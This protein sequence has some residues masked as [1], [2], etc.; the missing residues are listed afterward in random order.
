MF[1]SSPIPQPVGIYL[2]S[3]S[4]HISYNA[5][6]VVLLDRAQGLGCSPVTRRQ[7]QSPLPVLPLAASLRPCIS[8]HSVCEA[9]AKP[10]LWTR[11]T[12]NLKVFRARSPLQTFI[13]VPATASRQLE[14]HAA[15]PRFPVTRLAHTQELLPALFLDGKRPRVRASGKRHNATALSKRLRKS[16][17]R[18][19]HV[20]MER[21]RPGAARR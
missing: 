12:G 19:S 10:S 14:A 20:H 18:F 3:P 16:V 4:V 5:D 6:L 13:A 1:S 9:S 2:R 17:S 7:P 11:S 15:S 8:Y 21:G